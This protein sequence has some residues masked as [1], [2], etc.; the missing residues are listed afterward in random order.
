MVRHLLLR[1]I[2]ERLHRI[3][4]PLELQ[5]PEL[6][7]PELQHPELQLP[8]VMARLES[9]PL[10]RHRMDEFNACYRCQTQQQSHNVSVPRVL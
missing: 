9:E 7:H 3:D 1:Q 5:H 6:Q 2:E 8:I 4:Q 10:V